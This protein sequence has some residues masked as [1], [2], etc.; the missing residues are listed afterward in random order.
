M[1]QPAALPSAAAPLAANTRKT[2]AMVSWVTREVARSPKGLADVSASVVVFDRL[3]QTSDG[4][5]EYDRSVEKHLEEY[6]T[7]VAHALGVTD[8]KEMADR[9]EVRYLRSPWASPPVGVSRTENDGVTVFIIGGALLACALVVIVGLAVGRRGRDLA[10]PAEA[11]AV[12]GAVSENE[13]LS[14]TEVLRREAMKLVTEDVD[15]AAAVLG[16]W[17]ARE[18]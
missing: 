6:T 2:E 11:A 4:G 17:V 15:R 3:V 7:L 5:W 8:V 16:Q 12:A 10:V 18:V 9:I 13:A 14:R 1:N